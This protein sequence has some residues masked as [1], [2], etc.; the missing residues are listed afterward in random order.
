VAGVE[1]H[2]DTGDRDTTDNR[3]AY[4][5]LV[6]ISS[7][8]ITM[9]VPAGY[10]AI[11]PVSVTRSLAAEGDTAMVDFKLIAAAETGTIAGKVFHDSDSDG[12]IDAG[13]QGIASVSITLSSG[14]STVTDASGDYSFTVVPGTYDVT[15]EDLGGYMSTTINNITGVVIVAD[16]TVT[17]N[18]GDIFAGDLNFTVITLGQTQRALCIDSGDLGEKGDNNNDKEILL[19][20]KYVSGISN[21]NI[22]ENKW[23]N[24]STPNSAVFDQDPWYSRTPTED[25]LSISMG[26]LGGDSRNDVITGLTSASGKVLVWITQ[27]SGNDKGVL[28]TTPSSF[29]ISSGIADVFS[30]LLY[31]IDSDGDLDI[32]IGT[33]YL[34]T[35]GKFE[36][37]FNDGSGN[38]SN[39]ISD[40]YQMAGTHVLGAVMSLGVG[41]LV[42][43]HANDVVLGTVT[44]VNTGKIEIFRDNGAPNGRFAYYGTIEATG[45]VNAIA[46]C[47]MLEDSYG[48]LDIIAGTTTGLGTGTVELWL[49][50]G[51]GTFGENIGV[52]T[53]A[54]SDTARFNG[55]ILTLNAVR[56][57]RDIYPDIAVGLKRA[58]VYSGALAILQCYGY[59]PPSGSAWTSADIGEAI[60]LT[61]NDFNKDY[62]NDLAVGTRTDFSQGHVVVFFNDNN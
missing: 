8:S 21:L 62:A 35:Q 10:Q 29:F 12:V 56:M 2:L 33:E 5:F 52:G 55:E 57:D 48:D 11:G 59:M 14:D 44:G 28:P 42:G 50:N 13:E 20:T 16:T 54:P 51:D 19:G 31:P 46:L 18:F 38:F 53:Y 36:V 26:D 9:E 37:W 25:I 32:L 15:E 22:W 40:V 6:P 17:V 60:T 45:E 1:I 24:Q 4:M 3:G 58:G 27:G 43:S 7:Y 34:T 61:V 23:K 47:D 39:T 30:A 41:Q 49:N